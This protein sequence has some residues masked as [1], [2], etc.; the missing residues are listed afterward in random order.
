MYTASPR[1]Q[2]PPRARDERPVR[3]HP[4]GL[5][6]AAADFHPSDPAWPD[7]LSE[8]RDPPPLLRVAGALPFL[9]RAVAI[10]GTR[11]ASPD[12][13]RFAMS[14]ARD[15]ARAG[16]VVVSGGAEGIDSAAHRGALEGGGLG[17]AV[18][19][20][21]LAR[22]YPIAHAPLFEEIARNGAVITEHADDEPPL[23]AHF[24]ARNR[25]VAALSR[26]VVVVQAPF[27]S[28]ALATAAHARRLERPLLAA[29]WAVG[30]PRGEGCLSLLASG[31]RICRDASDVVHAVT[32]ARPGARRSRSRSAALLDPEQRAVLEALAATGS[33]VDEVV[34]AT[35][36]DAPRVQMSLTTLML[37]GLVLPDDRGA[38]RR[39]R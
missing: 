34:R 23:P 6:E 2:P 36:L 22:P 35:G 31:A 27:R 14:L 5:H 16:F 12:G 37:S 3:N 8:L 38:Y 4:S 28:G 33:H 7:C 26:A 9:D 25:L 1:T 39:S 15:L 10:V 24:L 29:P 13:L 11:R 18:L 21:G 32:G 20:G 30:D 17:I 19:A